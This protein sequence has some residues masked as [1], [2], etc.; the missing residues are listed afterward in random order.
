MYPINLSDWYTTSN[1]SGDALVVRKR[2]EKRVLK[3]L[4]MGRLGAP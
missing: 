2:S 4:H 1:I 3:R